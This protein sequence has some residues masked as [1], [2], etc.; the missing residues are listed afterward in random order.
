MY[1]RGDLTAVEWEAARAILLPAANAKS[2]P[3]RPMPVE[4]LTADKFASMTVLEKRQ[5]AL[6]VLAEHGA[7]GY[8]V[9]DRPK[10]GSPRGRFDST[11]LRMPGEGAPQVS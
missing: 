5:A 2:V 11:R 8:V 6:A 3:P 9:V 10:A 1:A 4:N 7:D